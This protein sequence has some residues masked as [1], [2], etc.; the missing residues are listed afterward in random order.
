M[1]VPLSSFL[2]LNCR[3]GLFT[4]CPTCSWLL[5]KISFLRI[6]GRDR[7]SMLPL[8]TLVLFVKKKSRELR[9]CCN[10][11]GLNDTT[12]QNR[13]PLP[14]ISELLEK[15]CQAKIFMKLDLRGVYN[16]VQICN[17]DE[18]KT[19]FWTR[20]GHFQYTIIRTHQCP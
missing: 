10:Y 14:P 18:W 20:N 3:W 15:L 6:G 17:E 5:F 12:I 1:I 16:L 19:A 11:W 4:S 13:Y 7:P 2:M 8:A 9:L